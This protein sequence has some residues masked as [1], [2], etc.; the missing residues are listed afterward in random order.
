[1]GSSSSSS[2]TRADRYSYTTTG[3]AKGGNLQEGA[4]Q[5]MV[6]GTRGN[7]TIE[8]V[9]PVVAA[10]SARLAGHAIDK[11]AALSGNSAATSAQL[12]GHV[13]DEMAAL[14]GDSIDVVAEAI[15]DSSAQ[16]A[17]AYAN[18][19][20]KQSAKTTRLIILSAAGVAVAFVF[21]GS[22]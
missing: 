7:V 1:M 13:I 19:N 11:M 21:F 18:A 2:S 9:N 12:A 17:A 6:S 4:T 20:T 15:G 16:I 14:S 10:T 22:G 5:T 3:Y 8:S